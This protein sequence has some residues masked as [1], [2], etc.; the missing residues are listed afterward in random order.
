VSLSAESWSNKNDYKTSRYWLQKLFLTLE[1]V[2]DD[3]VLS[4]EVWLDETFYR[5]RSDE[6]VLKE[7]GAK[8]RGLSQNQICI[9]VATD[10]RRTVLI[11]EGDGKPSQK[12]IAQIFRG[13]I[14]KGSTL[15]HDGETAH[16]KLITELSLKSRVYPANQLKNIP[17]KDNPLNPVNRVHATLKH[18]SWQTVCVNSADII[19]Q[20]N[21]Y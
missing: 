11:V 13:H 4:G 5:V 17:D 14:E 20:T 15:I 7:N 19:C 3:I 10:K 16:K 2:Q 6:M 8:L 1:G 18:W 21:T 9:G 12:G